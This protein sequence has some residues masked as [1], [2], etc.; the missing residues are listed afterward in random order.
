MAAPSSVDEIIDRVR[1]SGLVPPERFEGFLSDLSGSGQLPTTV[2]AFLDRLVD[3]GH[4]TRFHAERLAAGKYKGFILGSYMILGLLGSGGMGQV[5]LA[6]HTSMKRRVALKVLPV[7]AV[8]SNEEH[9]ARERFLREARVAATLDHPNIVRVF[10]LCEE[11]RLMYLVMEYVE[12]VSLQNLVA[13]NGPL[14]YAQAAH[15]GRQVAFGLQHAHEMG[16]VHRDIK[17]ANL[18]LDRTG[19]VKILDLGLVRTESDADR[20]LTLKLD[21]KG[22]LGT[23]D[24][25]APEQTVDSSNVDHRADLYSL[26]ATMYF[27]LAGRPLFPEG[28]TAQKL[29]WQQ[30]RE[31]VPIR[32]IRPEIPEGLAAI[33]HKLIQKRPGDRFASAVEVFDALQIWTQEEIAPPE[34]ALL[35]ILNARANG[36]KSGVGGSGRK[37]TAASHLVSAA[38]LS[39]PAS[40]RSGPGGS[41]SGGAD[42]GGASSFGPD[43]SG[44]VISPSARPPY[45][46]MDMPETCAMALDD[47][48]QPRPGV[49][50]RSLLEESA[51]SLEQDMAMLE[52]PLTGLRWQT[53]IL[54]GG[55]L[56]AAGMSVGGLVLLVLRG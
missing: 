43:S 18:L 47:T 17:P 5:Y 6:E 21:N 38:M 25:I 44:R 12:G 28:R 3:A 34:E 46:G 31:P 2:S 52:A 20:G 23:A 13:R 10:D 7:L 30:I 56:L 14:T 8:D 22:I 40:S 55:L 9:V 54:I 39:K 53:V 49:E 51:D 42:A 48:Q 36:G 29:V 35:P 19:V 4:I 41:S 1:R 50:D 15:Y 37:S 27:L 26:G 11:G 33:I 45:P 24:Y 32:R 16:C